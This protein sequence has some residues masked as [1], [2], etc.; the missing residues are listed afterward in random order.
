MSAYVV[1]EVRPYEF[2]GESG[3]VQ[4]V[5]VSYLDPDSP[6]DGRSRGYPTFSVTAPSSLLDSFTAVPGVYRLD[7]RMRAG[8]RGRPQL[9]LV[10]AQLERPI[11]LGA[12]VGRM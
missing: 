12:F 6:A 7:F 8:A 9:A 2:Q 5:R 3:R 1:L 10:G 11:D 4:G